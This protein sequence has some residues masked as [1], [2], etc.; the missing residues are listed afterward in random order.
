MMQPERERKKYPL[1]PY[2]QLVWDMMQA[3]KNVYTFASKARVKN[4]EE[5]AERITEALK[6]ALG[7]HPVFSMRVD[8]KGMQ[9]YHPADDIL[10]G[11]FHS[12]DIE[13]KGDYIELAITSNRILGDGISGILVMEDLLRT[14]RGL[15]LEKDDYIEY[16]EQTEQAKQTERY[17][18]DKQW[19]ETKFDRLTAPVHPTPDYPLTY[20]QG[21]EEGLLNDDWSDIQNAAQETGRE[22]MVT[23]TGIVSLAAALATMDYNGTDEAALTW[24]YDGRETPAEQRIY[25][26]LHRDIPLCISRE[27]KTKDKEQKR[28]LLKQVR[29]EMRQ[30]IVHSAY[31]YTLTRPHTLIWNY[32]L[33]VLQQPI[34]TETLLQM[35]F[36]VELMEDSKHTAYL[37]LD[38]EIYAGESLSIAYRYS[39]THYKQE[40][41]RRFAAMVKENAE[42][43]LTD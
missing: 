19:L 33:N 30:G 23:L 36:E 14:F 43:L 2:S 28:S 34:L 8:D 32:A 37:L 12:V 29:T 25:G 11:Q 35:P 18:A 4:E 5:R 24:A 13:E 20:A 1:L 16:L 41:I 17:V 21:W 7:N 27:R 15:P 10:H 39:A 6:T 40:S 42:W 3:D 31:P 26:S 22:Y 9:Y 38:V